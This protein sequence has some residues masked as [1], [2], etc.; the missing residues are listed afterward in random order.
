MT[1]SSPAVEPRDR[2]NVALLANVHPPDRV[3]PVPAIVTTWSS[4]VPAR[5]A[6]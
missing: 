3:N 4:W 6:S 5:P 2:Y 1:K